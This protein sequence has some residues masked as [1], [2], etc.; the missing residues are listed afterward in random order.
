MFITQVKPFL[1]VFFFF[2]FH[3]QQEMKRQKATSRFKDIFKKVRIFNRATTPIAKV[4][5]KPSS[6]QVDPENDDPNQG[7]K[8][9]QGGSLM[10]AVKKLG[11]PERV[12]PPVVEEARRENK[13]KLIGRHI[14]T[15]AF[16]TFLF[17]WLS[18]TLAFTVVLSS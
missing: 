7:L 17:I 15:I 6:D 9:N 3:S 12:L 8:I 2:F 13:Y 5:S 4:L 14:D 10:D 11:S 16:F 18:V 1:C